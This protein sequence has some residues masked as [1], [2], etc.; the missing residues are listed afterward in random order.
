MNLATTR[1]RRE[2]S[3]LVKQP[4][5]NPKYAERQSPGIKRSNCRAFIL[6]RCELGQPEVAKFHSQSLMAVIAGQPS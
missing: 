5:W 3:M 1:R 4:N 2:S 6:N